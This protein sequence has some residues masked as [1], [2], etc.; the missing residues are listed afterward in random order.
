MGIFNKTKTDDTSTPVATDAKEVKVV[1][2]VK[3]DKKETGTSSVFGVLLSPIVTEKS[4]KDEQFGK[5]TFLVAES[6]TKNEIKKAI[7]GRYG[8]KPVKVNVI[9]N[10]GKIKRYGRFWGK[11]KDTKKAVVTLPKGKSIS[12]YENK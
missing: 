12:I 2:P 3:A 9:S 7:V 10:E 5:Y 11:R 4:A 1:K 8:I 6:T